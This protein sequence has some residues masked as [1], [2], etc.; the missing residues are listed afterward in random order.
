MP[1]RKLLV[2]QIINGWT[3]FA[4][5][6]AENFTPCAKEWNGCKVKWYFCANFFSSALSLFLQALYYL[7]VG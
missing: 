5:T 4:D 2:G 6:L 7:M 3:V 1:L